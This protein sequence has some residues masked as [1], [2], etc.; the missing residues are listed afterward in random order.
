MKRNRTLK[1][2]QNKQKPGLKYQG[3]SNSY[4][5]V[6]NRRERRAQKESKEMALEFRRA[7][8][9]EQTSIDLINGLGILM[10]ALSR[11]ERKI[12]K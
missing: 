11:A 8:I 4:Q 6:S 7:A 5:A 10:S 3:I 1:Q 2:P 9:Q 12:S